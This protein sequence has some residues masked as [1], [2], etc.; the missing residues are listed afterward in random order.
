M[1]INLGQSLEALTQYKP[2]A[3]DKGVDFICMMS[4]VY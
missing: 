4:K 3:R 2:A 1:Y